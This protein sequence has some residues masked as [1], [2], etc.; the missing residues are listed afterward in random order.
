VRLN[1]LSWQYEWQAIA[2]RIEGLRIAGDIY[3][4]SIAKHSEDSFGTIRRVLLPQ[5][6]DI[7]HLFNNLCDN[8]HKQM[9]KAA[10]DSIKGFISNFRQNF[11]AE[12]PS[13]TFQYQL[14]VF[15][16]RIT[17]LLTLKAELD[18]LLSN[19]SDQIRH[20]AER[21]FDHLQRCIIADPSYKKNW[22]TGFS[23]GETYCEKLGAIHLLWHGISSFKVNAE[24]GRTDL[25][26]GNTIDNPTQVENSIG[27]VLTEWKQA[28]TKSDA[29]KKVTEAQNQAELYSVGVLGGIELVNP[30]YIVVVSKDYVA[31]P[32]D[33]EING[34]IYRHINLATEPSV[35][36][37]A[38]KKKA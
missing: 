4:K 3:F 6:E 25:I 30:R 29:E 2:A 32:S 36:S 33:I 21:A 5:A 22:I 24:G 17:S 38:S 16:N 37:V 27:L 9:P 18:Y 11:T 34:V 26:F 8:H 12:I 35:P 10:C 14:Q 23:T 7:Y 31:L 20:I 15:Q 19:A 1:K 13:S 28:T